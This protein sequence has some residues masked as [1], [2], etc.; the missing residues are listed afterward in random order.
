MTPC[1]VKKYES[2]DFSKVLL[3]TERNQSLTLHS[4]IDKVEGPPLYG[5]EA[6]KTGGKTDIDFKLATA[7]IW[8][9]QKK[10][11]NLRTDLYKKH[12]KHMISPTI[13]V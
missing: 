12:S 8:L 11:Q 10:K 7:L 5:T 13:R 6:D 9:Y 3:K 4:V 1:K 2:L